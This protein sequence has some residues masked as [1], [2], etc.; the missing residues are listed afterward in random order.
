MLLLLGPLE[1]PRQNRY[2]SSFIRGIVEGDD[3]TVESFI[4]DLLTRYIKVNEVTDRW[5]RRL[6]MGERRLDCNDTVFVL[7]CM[8]WNHTPPT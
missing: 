1:L 3:L 4:L 2:L 6:V 5:C 7:G 8:L